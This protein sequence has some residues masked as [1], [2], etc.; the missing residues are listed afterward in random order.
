MTL[1]APEVRVATPAPFASPAAPAADAAAAHGVGQH[2]AGIDLLRFAAAFMV[3]VDHYTYR[4][5]GEEK[6]L[7][8]FGDAWP[9][10]RS[11]APAT[12]FGWVGV[13]IFF[14][15]SG[16]VIAYS[17]QKSTAFQF[18]RSRVLRLMP[19][20]WICASVTLA[21]LFFADGQPLAPLVKGW[22]KAA[23]FFVAPN[24]WIDSVY[25]TLV[26]EVIFYAIVFALLCVGRFRSLKYVMAFIGLYSAANA[27]AL[28]LP[29]LGPPNNIAI[30]MLAIQPNPHLVEYG[31]FFALG[32]LIWLFGAT[33][34]VGLKGQLVIAACVIGAVMEIYFSSSFKVAQTP[35]LGLWS[36]LPVAVF[37]L[38]G[39]FMV[40]S[41]R[42]R[43]LFANPAL[44]R[45]LRVAGLMTYPLYLLHN[46][47]GK[48]VIERAMAAGAEAWMAIGAAMAL[49]IAASAIVA[50]WIEPLV[51]A[52]L[53]AAL[54]QIGRLAQSRGWAP[55]LFVTPRP[56]RVLI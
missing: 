24:G 48:V 29:V 10:L 55:F 28:V 36:P 17:A 15:I 27:I 38:S 46:F 31:S 44:N 4:G 8:V 20:I 56:N 41:F 49:S 42:H 39:V 3:M 40:W 33:G 32:V 54:D 26:I 50:M 53:R 23:F 22:L 30:S 45:L 12:W 47:A 51:R 11:L 6:G 5:W 14:V 9:T 52:P 1:P 7:L 37:V 25:W 18:L 35:D 2:V 19:A 16:F 13:E 34:K 43:G 21:V